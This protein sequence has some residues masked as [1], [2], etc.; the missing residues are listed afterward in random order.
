[1]HRTYVAELNAEVHS[2]VAA[3]DQVGRIDAPRPHVAALVGDA[4]SPF[5]AAFAAELEL[6]RE[7]ETG[8]LLGTEHKLH[9]P[10]HRIDVR[11]T[12]AMQLHETDDAALPRLG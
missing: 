9:H 6:A 11:C 10:H 4:H 7:V 12:H 5:A 8:G 2:S 3:H 1:F